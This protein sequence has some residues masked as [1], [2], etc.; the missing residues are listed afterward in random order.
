MHPR[1]A[2]CLCAC[3]AA[4]AVPGGAARAEAILVDPNPHPLP[5]PVAPPPRAVPEESMFLSAGATQAYV[6]G[7]DGGLGRF[8]RGGALTL[9]LLERRGELP[10]GVEARGVFLDGDG[11]QQFT[12][13]LHVVAS[14]KIARRPLVPFVALGLAAGSARMGDASGVAIGPSGAL[15]LHGFL[16]DSLYWRASASAIGVG[17]GT[18]VGELAVGWAFEP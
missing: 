10:T 18:L 9:A 3:A 14:A 16:A 17:A 8:G 15:G 6:S 13:A 7:A 12:L 1:A 11:G 2:A 4:I 5:L